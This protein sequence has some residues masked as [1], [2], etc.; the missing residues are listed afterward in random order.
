M[1]L[2]ALLFGLTAVAI[3]VVQAQ[4]P[5]GNAPTSPTPSDRHAAHAAL[6]KACDDDIQSLCADKKGREVMMCLRAST[7]KLSGGCKDALSTLHRPAPPQ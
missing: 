7:D 4:T 2:N 1:K 5:S 6:M 3:G